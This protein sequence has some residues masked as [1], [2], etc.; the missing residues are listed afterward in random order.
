MPTVQIKAPR[1][2]HCI[3]MWAARMI[4]DPFCRLR[5]DESAKFF[6]RVPLRDNTERLETRRRFRPLEIGDK[7]GVDFVY[8]RFRRSGAGK[9][10]LPA[11]ALV[12]RH[13]L[14]QRRDIRHIRVALDGEHR[15]KLQLAGLDQ[16]QRGREIREL[17][18]DIA[19]GDIGQSRHRAFVRDMAD[20][21]SGRELELLGENLMRRG[22]PGRRIGQRAGL[23]LGER[24]KIGHGADRQRRRNDQTELGKAYQHDGIEVPAEVIRDRFHD[25][26]QY[27]DRGRRME[28]CVA[29]GIGFR[30]KRNA[31]L[32]A[33]AGLV[34]DNE[35][36]VKR[37]P[38][39][40]GF[41]AAEK[42]VGCPRRKRHDDRYWAAGIFVSGVGERAE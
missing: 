30:G 11:A 32:A 28:Q 18:G 23:R 20:I 37:A 5:G 33:G 8:D 29:V 22:D 41:I 15:K 40:V 21:S 24:D 17:H 4:L 26:W 6:R 2:A 25:E 1:Y 9:H 27:R 16:R 36:A 31:D 38:Q 14:G 34:L 19:A 42:V 7:S 10:A 39:H 12:A 13:D 3:S 35:S